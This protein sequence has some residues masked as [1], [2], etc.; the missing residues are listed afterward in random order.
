MWRGACSEVPNAAV[1]KVGHQCSAEKDLGARRS[2][3]FGLNA[4]L[5]SRFMY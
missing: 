2:P 5:P 3:V 4:T 1:I